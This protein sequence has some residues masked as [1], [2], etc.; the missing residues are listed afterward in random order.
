M[1]NTISE[2]YLNQQTELHK[3]PKYGG[4]SLAYAGIVKNLFTSIKATSISDYGAGKCNLKVGLERAGLQNFTYYPYDPVFPQYGEPRE[5][6]LVCC[7]DVL[8][9]IEE[10]HLEN[11]INDLVR[12]TTNF[13][14]YTIAT[15]P[16]LKVLSDGKNAHL[17]QKQTSWWL[18][19][20]LRYFNIRHL[21]QDNHGFWFVVVPVSKS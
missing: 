17:I 5:A 15:G 14:F 12:I 3:N 11:V 1:R 7:I 13:G 20:F 10:D 9:H 19:K 2:H 21:Q 16:A 8:E 4:A 6:D 18:P